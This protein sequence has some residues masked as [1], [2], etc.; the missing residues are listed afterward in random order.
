[1][2]TPK[3]FTIVLD[4][5]VVYKTSKSQFLEDWKTTPVLILNK[6]KSLADS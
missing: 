1:M 5:K 4:K 2:V 6:H 3:L